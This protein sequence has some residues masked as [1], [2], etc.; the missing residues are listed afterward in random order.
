MTF[1]SYEELC[2]ELPI[3]PKQRVRIRKDS[4]IRTTHPKGPYILKRSYIVT[5]HDVSPGYVSNDINNIK[6]RNPEICWIGTGS[7]WFY[8]DMENVEVVK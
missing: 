7:Y 4:K 3:Q 1:K 5:V 2:A 6:N 8:T